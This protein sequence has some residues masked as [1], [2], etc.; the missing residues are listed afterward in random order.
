M[1]I[2]TN[3]MDQMKKKS[4]KRFARLGEHQTQA[5]LPQGYPISF[6]NTSWKTDPFRRVWMPLK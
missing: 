3:P 2:W 5:Y 6:P 1:P 4:S